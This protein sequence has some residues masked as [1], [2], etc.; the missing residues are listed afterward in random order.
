MAIEGFT[1]EELAHLSDDAALRRRYD[2]RNATIMRWLIWA[3]LLTS[4]IQMGAGEVWE[5]PWRLS[6]GTTHLVLNAI[7][8]LAFRRIRKERLD[9]GLLLDRVARRIENQMRLLV[10]SYLVVEF[11]LI[12]AFHFGWNED[13]M[14]WFVTFPY[15]LVPLRF[16]PAE[17]LFLHGLIWGGGLATVLAWHA[18]GDLGTEAIVAS[19][20][21]HVVA[22]FAGLWMN[23][24]FRKTFLR[25]WTTE[26]DRAREQVRMREEL[27]FAREIQLSMLPRESPDVDWLDISAVSLPA[28]EVGGDYFDYFDAG[29]ERI[30]VVSCDVAGH[31]MASGIVL[32]GVRSCL[33]LLSEELGDPSRVMEKMHSMVRQTSRHRMLVTLSILLLDRRNER[34]VLTSAGHPPVL[35]RKPGGEVREIVIESLPLGVRLAHDW[36]E[37]TFAIAPGDVIVLQTDGV[38]ETVNDLDEQYGLD[39]LMSLIGSWTD[40]GT[41]QGLRD[42]IIRDLWSFRGKAAQEDDVTLVVIRVLE[43]G[44]R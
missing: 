19:S 42:G 30:A 3:G 22:F 39:R 18:P 6:I 2:Q 33:T 20:V 28:T 23:H 8:A 13:V 17:R 7:L 34:A 38:Y 25:E 35:V 43:T 32:S 5:S 11:F 29:H 4:L 9:D 1:V 31:G 14:P 26:R 12:I 41:A 40:D 21:Q 24:R 27:E 16:I 10:Q 44:D 15:L 36:S 37:E